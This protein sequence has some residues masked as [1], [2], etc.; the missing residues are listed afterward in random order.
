MQFTQRNRQQDQIYLNN[1]AFSL[2]ECIENLGRKS[3]KLRL[4][5]LMHHL[6]MWKLMLTKINDFMKR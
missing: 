5:K 1:I 2:L 6:M 3:R 4:Q